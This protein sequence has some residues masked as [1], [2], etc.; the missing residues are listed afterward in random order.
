MEHLKHNVTRR[1]LWHFQTVMQ[2]TAFLDIERKLRI[3]CNIW[4]LVGFKGSRRV[5]P[6]GSRSL[7]YFQVVLGYLKENNLSETPVLEEICGT[8][9]RRKYARILS[10]VPESITAVRVPF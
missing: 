10:A 6:V 4:S 2:Y 8:A 9:N 1:G 5:Y 3:F 7:T